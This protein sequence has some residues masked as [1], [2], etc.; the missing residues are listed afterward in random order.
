MMGGLPL[1]HRGSL[2]TSL[3]KARFSRRSRL[4]KLNQ[5]PL[6]TGAAEQAG[7]KKVAA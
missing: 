4:S 6:F 7:Q 2:P 5:E 1:E 3:N